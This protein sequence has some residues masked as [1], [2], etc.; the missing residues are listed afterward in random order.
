MK[1]TWMVRLLAALALAAVIAA[2][3]FVLDRASA[4]HG[5]APVAAW[6]NGDEGA[7]D[8]AAVEQAKVCLLIPDCFRNS[9]CDAQCGAGQGRCVHNDC[10][11]RVCRCR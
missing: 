4:R 7:A 6:Q 9:D 2:L 8:D 3:P 11:A 5:Q 10:P 1:K